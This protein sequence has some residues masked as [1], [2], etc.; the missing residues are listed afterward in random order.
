MSITALHKNRKRRK[1][2]WHKQPKR[3]SLSVK[4]GLLLMLTFLEGWMVCFTLTHSRLPQPAGT[5]TP[6]WMVTGS[7]LLAVAIPFLWLLVL[8]IGAEGED[9]DQ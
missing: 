8:A 9:D 3:L 4:G 1:R 2:R 7:F 5:G 6:Q